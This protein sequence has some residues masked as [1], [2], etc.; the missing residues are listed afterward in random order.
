MDNIAKGAQSF[1]RTYTMVGTVIATIIS[2]ILLIVAFYKLTNKERETG[3]TL[4]KIK[5]A[6]CNSHVVGNGNNMKMNFLCNLGIAYTVTGIEYKGNLTSDSD[7]TYQIDENIEVQYDPLD[8]NIV[9][10]KTLSNK[11]IGY[12]LL[13][14]AIIILIISWGWFYFVRHNDFVAAGMGVKGL[15][16]IVR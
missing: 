3:E 13:V 1:G 12:I 5:V 4:A 14:I 16:D 10:L 6:T 11:T 8:P 7:R 15:F 9:R 2:I